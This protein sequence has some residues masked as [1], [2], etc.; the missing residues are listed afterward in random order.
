MKGYN[1]FIL[2]LLGMLS[3][4]GPFVTDMFVPAM[5]S[6]VTDLNTTMP[7]V[8]LGLTTSML[9]LAVGQL[10]FGPISDKIGRRRPVL[11]SMALFALAS[12]AI[13]YVPTIE[14]FIGLR[15]VQGLAGAGGIVISR[16]VATDLF[17]GRQLM[18][19]LAVIGAINGVTPIAAPVVGGLMVDSVGWRGI[20]EVLLWVGVVLLICSFFMRE[21]LPPERRQQ[22]SLLATF[23]L[24]GKVVRN[25]K[26]MCYTFEQAAAQFILFGNIASSSFIVQDHYGYSALAYSI[27]F[28][29]NGIAIGAGAACSVRFRT[30]QRCINVSCAGMLAFS[31]LMAIVLWFNGNFWIYET[32]LCFLLFFMGLTFTASTTLALDSER[33][34]AGTGSALFGAVGFVAGGVV[35]PL[36]GMGNMLHSTAIVM[37]TGAILATVFALLSRRVPATH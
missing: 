3:A 25:R 28:A 21:S 19:M 1:I 29:V 33:E 24:F 36:V 20:F 9:G 18:K 8:Q 10:I 26:F 12:V 32:V 5:P 22:R 4:F 23:G 27:A 7:M 30:P 13:I 6:M 16:S 11:W 15:F 37:L 2:F 17:D 14:G 35:S 34:E 31:A